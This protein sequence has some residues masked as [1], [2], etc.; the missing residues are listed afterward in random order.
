MNKLIT[1]FLILLSTF[2]SASTI[3]LPKNSYRI[4]EERKI[5][6]CNADLSKLQ[7]DNQPIILIINDN[8]SKILDNVVNLKK[9][10]RYTLGFGDFYQSRY[11]I[12]FTELPLL[13]ID[14]LS[15][16]SDTPKVLSKINLVETS[17]KITESNAGIEYRGATSQSYPKKSYEIEFWNDTVGDDTQDL[18][19]LGMREDKDWNFQAMYNETLKLNSVTAWQLW[20]NMS[21]LY[22]KDLEPEAKTGINMKY[23]EVFVNN[24]YQ[25]IYA[26]SEKVDRKQLKL[27]KNTETEIRGELYKGDQWDDNTTYQGITSYDNTSEIWGGYEYKYP[28][29]LRDWSNF[30]NLHD[31]AINSSDDD[32]YNSYK[33]KYDSDNLIDYFIF[34]NTIRAK[35][36]TGKNIYTAR[37]NKN[38]RYFFI[39][40]DLDGVFGR[41][42]DS[43]S[44]DITDDLL[45][46]GLYNR[47]FN[48]QRND[49]FRYDLNK[50]WLELRASTI[51]VDKI[52]QLLIDNFDYLKTNGALERDQLA[53]SGSTIATEYEEFAYI[54]QWLIRRLD[55]LD[56]TFAFSPTEIPSNNPDI[57]K[58]N[59]KIQ[60]YPNPAKNY[61][62]FIDKNNK[63]DTSF[64]DIE[65]YDT[66]G[67]RAKTISQQPITQSVF[68]G[69]LMNGRYILKVKTSLGFKQNIKLIIDK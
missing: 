43:T 11:S 66:S 61:I 69:N 28:K 57:E 46:N 15:E 42:W 9:G 44:E 14:T 32:F 62:Y 33:Q 4:D 67:R 29:D 51:T 16:I 26:I 41:I 65:I 64:L 49:G 18:S 55:Y 6:V 17:G 21:S 31:F 13:F 53:N 58:T 54:R 1:L 10:I 24:S 56:K 22:Y 30:Y 47:L 37:Y 50:R 40:W 3:A 19:L 48:D 34:S 12:F 8:N 27:K 52:M 35:D 7:F 39:P 25:G 60:L 63:T 20:N 36:N 5:I 68:I 45:S 59:N 2:S 38:E 23:V